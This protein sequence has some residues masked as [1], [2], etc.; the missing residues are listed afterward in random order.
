[1]H[2]RLGIPWED[3]PRIRQDFFEQYGTTLRGIEVNYAVNSEDY[4]NFVHDLPL[5]DYIEPDAELR[6]VLERLPAKKFIF[7]NADAAHA[8]RVLNVL[9]VEGCFDGVLDVQLTHPF[10]KPQVEALQ[11]ALK[12]AGEDDPRRCALIDDLPST[13]RAARDFGFYS[14]LYGSKG[15]S[16]DADAT[17]L[18]WRD[19]PALLNGKHE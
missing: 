8:N 15:F 2:E 18:H 13:T 19:L 6:G 4:L 17:I 14:I 11:L 7:T 3:V 12:V 9:K 1:M 16:V 10:C 5:G